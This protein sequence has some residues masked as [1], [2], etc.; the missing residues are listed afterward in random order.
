VLNVTRLERAERRGVMP[1]DPERFRWDNPT[2]FSQEWEEEDFRAACEAALL[3]DIEAE[4]CR[5]LNVNTWN[6]QSIAQEIDALAA[7]FD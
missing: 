5:R 6:I 4:E 2:S 3:T 1:L 7:M